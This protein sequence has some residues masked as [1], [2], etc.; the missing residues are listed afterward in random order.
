MNPPLDFADALVQLKLLTSQTGNFTFTDDEITQALQT[1]WNDTYV[2][3]QVWDSSLTFNGGTWQYAI[4]ATVTTVRGL[5]FIRVLG[6]DPEPISSDLYEVVAGNI[7]FNNSVTRWLGDSYTIYVK[8]S[9]K[10]TTT[11]ELETTN[12]I[13][14]VINL[15]AE[16]L[17]TNLVMKRTFV[18]LR[19][20]TSMT[21]IARAL[22][23]IQ[24][25][26]LRYKQA[27]LREFE[28]A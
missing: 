22:Q 24:G 12:L 18:F 19:N 3:N 14:Y 8:G 28:S 2:V 15:A 25:N 1:A 5:Y 4:P 26:V 10:L 13:N 16:I 20:D 27:I 23:I 17:L 6:N 9:Y 7:Q 11:D 21:D